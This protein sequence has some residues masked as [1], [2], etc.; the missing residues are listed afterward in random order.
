MGSGG[1]SNVSPAEAAAYETKVSRYGIRVADLLDP[2]VLRDK[3]E[4]ACAEKNAVLR[5][6]YAKQPFDPKKLY[7]DYT[8]FGEV[9]A[10]RVGSGEFSSFTVMGDVVNVASRLE[11][12]APVGH[13]LVGEVAYRLTRHVVRYKPLAPAISTPAPSSSRVEGPGPTARPCLRCSE[14]RPWRCELLRTACRCPGLASG[15]MTHTHHTID[16]IEL[17]VVDLEASKAFYSGAFG[18]QFNDYGPD[19]AGIRTRSGD[20]EVGGLGVGLSL[21]RHL[22]ELHGG[23]VRAESAGAGRGATFTIEL[24]LAG[25]REEAATADKREPP[26]TG[27]QQ[28]DR[29]EQDGEHPE[30]GAEHLQQLRQVLRGLEVL[31]LHDLDLAL[32][33]PELLVVHPEHR[34]LGDRRMP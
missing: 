11:E 8:R 13:T 4:F 3:I 5:D 26:P 9:L 22:V 25:A 19:Y 15:P 6:L 34:H 20:G 12:L 7:D 2:D 1:G 27:D 32:V 16:Y 10:G 23:T 29:R 17:N 18:W 33:R 21:V 14:R 30:P 28:G 31:R 24:P